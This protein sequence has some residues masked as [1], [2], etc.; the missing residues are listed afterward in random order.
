MKK[1]F[2]VLALF[3]LLPLG[4]LI[5]QEVKPRSNS[6]TQQ[7][8]TIATRFDSKSKLIVPSSPGTSG[9]MPL[10]DTPSPAATV[11]PVDS[12]AVMPFQNEPNGLD[13]DWMYQQNRAFTRFYI[14][15]ANWSQSYMAMGEFLK[16]DIALKWIP[17]NRLAVMAGGTFMRQYDHFSP[18]WK[19]LYG[20]NSSVDYH[21]NNRT[22]LSLYGTYFFNARDN[23][24]ANNLL[25]PTSTIGT[26]VQY[27]VNK[28][29][30]I[31]VGIDYR[32]DSNKNQW[33]PQS[34]S[35]VSVGF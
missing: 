14:Y 2:D 26:S 19:D 17:N 4:C 20:I 9:T 27:Q 10:S 6:T 18:V 32:Y 5:A 21:L 15:Q 8:D 34:G 28:K 33:K 24:F 3:A 7:V 29:T 11:R 30:R 35:K 13:S 22:L 1:S 25:F 12:L 31:G 23:L 16:Y